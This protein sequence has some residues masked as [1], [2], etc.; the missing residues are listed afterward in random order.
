MWTVIHCSNWDEFES[1]AFKVSHPTNR[2]SGKTINGKYVLHF[3]E[4]QIKLCI[5]FYDPRDTRMR[6][7]AIMDRVCD[8]LL[9]DEDRKREQSQRKLIIEIRHSIPWLD[10]SRYHND[11]GSAKAQ[12]EIPLL[13]RPL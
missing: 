2:Y 7:C 1:E 12:C 4:S 10:N 3:P 9:S 5:K 6:V 13:T 8:S 11:D